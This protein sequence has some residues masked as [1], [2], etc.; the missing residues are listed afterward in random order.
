MSVSPDCVGCGRQ[1]EAGDR[2]CADCGLALGGSSQGGVG[3]DRTEP[4][5]PTPLRPP[6]RSSTSSGGSQPAPAIDGLRRIALAVA[7]VLVAVLGWRVFQPP[8]GSL[9]GVTVAL[10][11]IDA[12]VPA[13]WSNR[14]VPSRAV[15]GDDDVDVD[16]DVEPGGTGSG[17][18][19]DVMVDLL[20]VL[21][22]MAPDDLVGLDDHYVF[23]ANSTHAVRLDP[24][25]GAA[26]TYGTTA[27]I[28]GH[29]GDRLVLATGGG[30]I[31]LASIANPAADQQVVVSADVPTPIAVLEVPGDGTVTVGT[32][33]AT[34][35]DNDE[36]RLE[37]VTVD[38]DSTE[39]T[40]RLATE[41]DFATEPHL[42]TWHGLGFQ[43]GYGTFDTRPD[44]EP[45]L[46]S[47]GVVETAGPQ[48]VLIR[49][50]SDP[51]NCERFWLDRETGEQ[52]DRHLPDDRVAGWRTDLFG[53][54]DRFLVL[55]DEFGRGRTYFDTETGRYLSG[56]DSGAGSATFEVA[57]EVV[58]PDG[59][60]LLAPT[61][62]GVIVHDLSSGTSGLIPV[63]IPGSP[64]RIELVPKPVV[65]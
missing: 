35:G 41:P 29:D 46:L 5:G 1:P 30:E 36:A 32:W 19:P 11:A 2:F 14:S 16:V 38:L 37:L 50:C 24:A 21:E 4:A 45:R 63:D 25:S 58:S 61:D 53:P 42:D 28:V 64:L 31:R 23:A 52:A 56:G 62:D 8:T 43:P 10:D 7:L 51:E 59:R 12:R 65:R 17:G 9:D 48:L 34:G 26:E 27:L 39:S 44:G 6:P 33:E 22:V 15:D 54:D 20:D 18:N 49:R 60:Y 3:G 40:D 57:T 13:G 55:N 47:D